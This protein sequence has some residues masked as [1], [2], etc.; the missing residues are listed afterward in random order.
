MA[1]EQSD[2]LQPPQQRDEPPEQQDDDT[3]PAILEAISRTLKGLR[4]GQV[5]AIVRDGKVV[6]IDR[7]ERKRLV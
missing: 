5:T 2:R 7:T 6:Q 3:S 4:Y 1:R